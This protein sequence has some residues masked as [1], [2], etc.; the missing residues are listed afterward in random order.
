MSNSYLQIVVFAVASLLLFTTPVI[1]QTNG[2]TTLS[3][4]AGTTTDER[5]SQELYEDAN[6]Y[7]GRK[8]AEFNKQKRGYD[9]KLEAKT[10]QEQKE[11][12]L[13]NAAT[14][15]HRKDLS[16]DDLYYLGMLQH[17]ASDS[18]ATLKVMRRY[19]AKNSKGDKS[20]IARAVVVLH[21]TR[22]NLLAEAEKTVA[23]YRK[24]EPIDFNELYGMEALL[25]EAFSKANNYAQMEAHA[26]A[27][28]EV[29][30]NEQ[31][32]KKV[33]SFKRD[34]RLF[35]AASQLAE[36]L[37]KTD[38]PDEALTTLR[39]LMK[40]SI[41]LPSGNLY[42]MARI[43]LARLDPNADPLKLLSD[44]RSEKGV[45]PEIVGAQWI[46]QQP[47]KLADLRGQV[48]LLDFWAHWCGPCQYVFP[49]LQRWHESYKD[50]GLVILGMTNYFGQ[51]N[52]RRATAT[53]EL[54]YL[55]DFKKRNR[56]PYGFVVSDSQINDANY[57]VTSIPMSFLIDRNGSVRFIAVGANEQETN[58]LGKKIKEL[59][60]EP[61]PASASRASV[62]TAQKQ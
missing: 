62:G 31:A 39:D 10:K 38:R 23:A 36:A 44:M 17:L 40:L 59:I 57:G 54:A 13:A 27:M 51:T 37:L 58:A 46:D 52:G 22:T 35:K 12:A 55:R 7:L 43:R 21:A 42:K 56:L 30:R 33:S 26:R 48:V 24:A 2:T 25:T 61:A 5:T 16:A 50:K 60:E 47:V 29:A 53:E 6:G 15:S 20:Q 41:S 28:L 3:A 8:Y 11:L 34:E 49:K 14:L 9:A 4:A 32:A 45:P 19:L 1:S 18:E